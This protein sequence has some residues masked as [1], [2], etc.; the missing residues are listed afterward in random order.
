LEWHLQAG[1]SVNSTL[2]YGRWPDPVP[3]KNFITF[4]GQNTGT[5]MLNVECELNLL[6]LKSK[7]EFINQQGQGPSSELQLRSG[8]EP[9]NFT[10][11]FTI[12]PGGKLNEK[13]LYEL[14]SEGS[15]YASATI[16]S[17]NGN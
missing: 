15:Y 16:R 2:Q 17:K 10:Y 11:D 7:P 4:T 13:V 12:P 1:R 6:P 3:G 8:K 5:E 14:S 9:L